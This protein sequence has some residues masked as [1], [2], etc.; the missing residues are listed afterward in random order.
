[1]FLAEIHVFGEAH[2]EANS[3]KKKAGKKGYVTFRWDEDLR[4]ST[5]F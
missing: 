1:M 3:T 5:R 4:V 2:V